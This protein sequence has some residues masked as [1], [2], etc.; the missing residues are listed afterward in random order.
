[1]KLAIYS[2]LKL[3]IMIMIMMKLGNAVVDIA[4]SSRT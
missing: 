3:I 1:L 2:V 4:A